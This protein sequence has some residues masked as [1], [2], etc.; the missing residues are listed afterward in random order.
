[1]VIKEEPVKQVL[2]RAY[3]ECGEEMIKGRVVK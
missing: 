2:Q 1:M 3:C